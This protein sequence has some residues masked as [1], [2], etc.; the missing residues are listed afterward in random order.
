M[1]GPFCVCFEMKQT[2]NFQ[3]QLYRVVYKRSK[4]SKMHYN[5][6]II[7]FRIEKEFF[8]LTCLIKGHF[9]KANLVVFYS[10]IIA[11]IYTYMC[12][13]V[14]IYNSLNSPLF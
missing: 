12:V 14:F 1:F 3:P 11:N 10:L 2:E 6:S 4:R 13:C 8:F 5:I 7:F 9:S